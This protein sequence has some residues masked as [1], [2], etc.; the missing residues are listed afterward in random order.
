MTSHSYKP[1]TGPTVQ[2]C[3]QAQDFNTSRRNTLVTAF[4]TICIYIDIDMLIHRYIHYGYIILSANQNL[5]KCLCWFSQRRKV[6]AHKS[7]HV[8][9]ALNLALGPSFAQY[10]KKRGPALIH[11]QAPPMTFF[12]LALVYKKF[13]TLYGLSH[14]LSVTWTG[15]CPIYE[16]LNKK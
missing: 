6:Y 16:L 1:S 2:H 3:K 14:L 13:L 4:P 15:C 12:L 10:K 7:A 9:L 11:Q 5:A 8:C